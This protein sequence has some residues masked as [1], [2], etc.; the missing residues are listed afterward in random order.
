MENGS[1]RFQV[2]FEVDPED[3]TAAVVLLQE[4]IKPGRIGWD[5]DSEVLEVRTIDGLT[6]EQIAVLRDTQLQ[7]VPQEAADD[8]DDDEASTGPRWRL[9]PEGSM[10]RLY[11]VR[12]FDSRIGRWIHA[13]TRGGLVWGEGALE[14]EGGCWVSE[15]SS[16]NSRSY[17]RGD[18]RVHNN[19]HLHNHSSVTGMSEIIMS[20]LD[21]CEIRGNSQVIQS[22]LHRTGMDD[23]TV[24]QST[25]DG[26]DVG[27]WISLTHARLVECVVKAPTGSHPGTDPVLFGLQ[28][29]EAN[30]RVGSE[31]LSVQTRW[32]A[33]SVFRSTGGN[34][35]TTP[36]HARWNVGCQQGT[37]LDQL[38]DAAQAHGA[39]DAELALLEP[40]W[41]LACVAS[42]DWDLAVP[43]ID[44]PSA[45]P[46]D[47]DL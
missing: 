7:P 5:L 1:N 36:A 16:L 31:V 9:E 21:R 23:S 3:S 41:R 24:Q 27:N 19:S 34:F 40:F 37:T 15:D 14:Q 4:V 12:S 44:V 42:K 28:A 10:F 20:T 47:A 26:G 38:R 25:I 45:P 22:T 33:L 6:L 11:A 32:G 2:V 39:S 18:A 17:I 13:G 29:R 35:R 43:M 8:D 46:V 30:L